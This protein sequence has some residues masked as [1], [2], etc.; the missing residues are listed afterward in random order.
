MLVH[1][2]HHIFSGWK[3]YKNLWEDSM[4]KVLYNGV[5]RDMTPE[6]QAQFDLDQAA[7]MPEEEMTEAELLARL[8]ALL[9]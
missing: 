3:F 7:P 2:G 8:E 5:I 6:E 4:S 1:T 9:A